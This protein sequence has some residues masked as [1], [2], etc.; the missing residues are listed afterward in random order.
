[1]NRRMMD[2]SIVVGTTDN[3]TIRANA[4]KEHGGVKVET[5]IKS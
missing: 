4:C 1:M 2:S 3:A 5:K